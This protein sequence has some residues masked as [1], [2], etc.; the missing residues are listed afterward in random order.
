MEKENT[1]VILQKMLTWVNIS[2]N[3]MG[4]KGNPDTMEKVV[5]NE[6]KAP[7]KGQVEASR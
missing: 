4:I 6:Q 7:F 3:Q 5:G 1:F 2:E